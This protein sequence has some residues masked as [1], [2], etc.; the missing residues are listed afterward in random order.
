MPRDP[1]PTA[2]FQAGTD[3]ARPRN[4]CANQ[5]DAFGARGRPHEFCRLGAS[6][7]SDRV[8]GTRT[9]L[10]TEHPAL[11]RRPARRFGRGPWPTSTGTSPSTSTPQRSSQRRSGCPSRPTAITVD[12]TIRGACLS[13]IPIL[14]TL[15]PGPWTPS[16]TSSC[17]TTKRRPPRAP[18]RSRGSRTSAYFGASWYSTPASSTRKLAF[19]GD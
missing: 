12:R 15:T 7:P 3:N 10:D 14:A 17:C 2:G 13:S 1:H 5:V 18:P 6:T 11:F 4:R 19:T 16:I 8:R 9:A